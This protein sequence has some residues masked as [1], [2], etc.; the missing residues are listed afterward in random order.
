MNNRVTRISVVVVLAM[1][2]A[3]LALCPARESAAA[4][5]QLLIGVT[6]EPTTID[7]SLA[8]VGPDYALAMNLGEFLIAGRRAAS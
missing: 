7:P 2:L 8:W 5:R 1:A 6:Q 4:P 3:V